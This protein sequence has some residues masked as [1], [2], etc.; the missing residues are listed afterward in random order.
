MYCKFI[1]L[2]QSSVKLRRK[3]IT[4][5]VTEVVNKTWI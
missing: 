5:R 2:S 4:A 1:I 3:D